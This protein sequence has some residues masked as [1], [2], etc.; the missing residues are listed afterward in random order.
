MHN[1][2]VDCRTGMINSGL[3]LSG[4]QGVRLNTSNDEKDA[5]NI[6]T[7]MKTIQAGVDDLFSDLLMFTNQYTI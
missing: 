7:I 6:R 3:Y 2:H 1:I 5:V 4:V